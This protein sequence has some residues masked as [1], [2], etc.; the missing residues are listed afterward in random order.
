[1]IGVPTAASKLI[2]SQA[3]HCE[4]SNLATRRVINIYNLIE[5]VVTDKLVQ[6]NSLFR[7]NAVRNLNIIDNTQPPLKIINPGSW[8]WITFC[9]L[10]ITAF[11][12]WGLLGKVS[13]NVLA[14][15]I[16]LP[17]NSQV[18][19]IL[20]LHQGNI[21]DVHVKQGTRLRKNMVMATVSNPYVDAD[22]KYL[23]YS[24]HNNEKLLNEF[25]AQINK[26]KEN[27]LEEFNRKEA[28]LKES[29]N[30]RENKFNVLKFLLAK[31]EVLYIKKSKKVEL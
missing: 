3:R 24:Y 6:E 5:V 10:F 16:I 1:V 15:G 13:I 9:V 7:P 27:I 17:K 21:A 20:A 11:I 2:F 4:R 25:S 31:K 28:F 30:L 19:P 26:K 14:N 22:L 23:Q 8:A 18:I 12:M 29:L